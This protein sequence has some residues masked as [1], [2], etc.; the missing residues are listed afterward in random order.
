LRCPWHFNFAPGAHVET[1]MA[2][3]VPAQEATNKTDAL[4]FAVGEVEMAAMIGMS[5]HWLRKDRRTKRLIPFFKL[6]DAV[7]YSPPRV[8]EAMATLEHGGPRARKHEQVLA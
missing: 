1:R 7:R 6:G 4:P 5:P 2:P 3:T 8:F